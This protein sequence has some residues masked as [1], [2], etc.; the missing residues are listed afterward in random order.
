[1]EIR[2]AT[3]DDAADIAILRREN[4]V[5]E[6]ILALTSERSASVCE[7]LSSLTGGDRALAALDGG[8]LVGL[9]VLLHCAAPRRSHCASVAVM[10][11]AECQGAGI[12]RALMK[13]LLAEADAALHYRRLELMVLADNKPALELYRK[14]GFEIEARRRHAAVANGKFVDEYLMA[15]INREVQA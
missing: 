6:G 8:R 1:M 9:A 14:N 7:F 12:G 10:V 15:R 2:P 3:L 4:G 5:R 11:A 13:R